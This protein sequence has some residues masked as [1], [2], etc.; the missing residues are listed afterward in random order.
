MARVHRQ[1]RQHR[2]NFL[3]K[4]FPRPGRAFGVQFR[5]VANPDS[6]F[7]QLRKQFLVPKL[8]LGCD[9]LVGQA[10]DL[11]ERLGRTQSIRTN[12]AGFALD[13]LLDASDANF[14]KLVQVRTENGKETSPARSTAESGPALLPGRG[15]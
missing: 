10:L 6:V 4:I 12:V 9:Q 15:D 2:K 14:K 7:F 1:R 13:L 5:N 3:P 11:V 8:V